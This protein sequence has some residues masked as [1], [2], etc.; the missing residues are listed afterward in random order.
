MKRLVFCFD[1]TW[2][3][4]DASHPTNVVITAESIVPVTRNGTVQQIFYHEGVG[5][6][7]T[8]RLMGGIFG[9]GVVPNIADAYR[10]LIFNYSPGDEIYVF[11]FSRGAY[12]ARSF[13]GL[14]NTVGIIN[15]A[16]AAKVGEAIEHYRNRENSDEFLSQMLQFRSEFSAGVCLSQTEDEWRT[17]N[18]QGYAAGSAPRVQIMYLGVWDTVG[19]LG[20]PTRY[21]LLS[22][23]NRKLQFHDTTLSSFVRSAR[24][25]IAI[26]ERRKDFVPT[27]WE[28][29]D[30]LNRASGA[31]GTAPDAPYQEKWFPGTHSSVGGGGDRRGLSDQA[32]AW[33]LDGAQHVGLELDSS[34]KTPIYSLKP[35]SREFLQDSAEPGFFYKAMNA[36]AAADRMPG[37]KS[38]NEVSISA[39]R[40]WKE[41]ATDLLDKLEY[42][43]AT[44]KNVASQLDALSAADVGLG[45]TSAEEGTYTLYSVKRGD[46]LRKIAKERL[47]DADRASEIYDLNRDKLESPDLI[48][49]GQVLRLPGKPTDLEVSA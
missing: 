45:L 28:N 49:V 10:T 42:R 5:T 26:D 37:P 6:K 8:D 18:C 33:V 4:L 34:D 16:D 2:N 47:G 44:L 24:H 41:S 48:Y 22:P 32:L 12:S 20:I 27:L 15:R 46:A 31:D 30:E 43:P 40:R 9:I 29:V 19:A 25:A 38:L 11:G 17:K 35:N 7:K 39:R 13:V 3:K 23:F 21:T 1:G 36:V 14:I